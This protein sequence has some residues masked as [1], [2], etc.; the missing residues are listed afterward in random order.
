MR[1]IQSLRGICSIYGLSYVQAA[2]IQ[3]LIDKRRG[4]LHPYWIQLALFMPYSFAK[5]LYDD[6]ISNEWAVPDEVEIGGII[7]ESELTDEEM[8]MIALIEISKES[9]TQQK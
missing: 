2:T 7:Y 9:I 6:L 4:V 8:K 5:R 1:P 3:D